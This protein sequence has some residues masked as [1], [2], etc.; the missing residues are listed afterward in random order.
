MASIGTLIGE[1]VRFAINII[2]S[3]H[4]VIAGAFAADS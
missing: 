4:L 2:E 3:E 1:D